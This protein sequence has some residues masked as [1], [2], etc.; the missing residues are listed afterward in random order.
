MLPWC[1]RRIDFITVFVIDWRG[2]GQ[3]LN[4]QGVV[5]NSRESGWSWD[6]CGAG[7]KT[8]RGHCDS[9]ITVHG[10]KFV[11]LR[12]SISLALNGM[13]ERLTVV[14]SKTVVVNGGDVSVVVLVPWKI[15]IVCT[16][17][18]VVLGVYV[19][20]GVYLEVRVSEYVLVLKVVVVG[21]FPVDEGPICVMHDE[22]VETVSH[23]TAG[24][25]ARSR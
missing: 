19:R 18:R 8:R 6:R 16:R 10:I 2:A 14:I 11:L 4:D 7:Y 15:V 13:C 25:R 5:F 17:V 1:V 3:R 20:S 24:I 22:T 23:I 12:Q 9:L 21:T